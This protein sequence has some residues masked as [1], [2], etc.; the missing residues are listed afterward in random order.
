VLLAPALDSTARGQSIRAA[1]EAR[2]TPTEQ[3]SDK[4]LDV[5]ADTEHPQGIVAI[6][7]SPGWSLDH[8]E[9]GP[10]TV[11]LVLDGVQDPGN[12][13]TIL[14]TSFG[15]G[16]AGVIALP[17]TADLTNPQVLRG[18][19]GAF[20]KLPSVRVETDAYVSW[21]KQHALSVLTSAMDGRPVGTFG[22][23]KPCALVLGN[24]GAGIREELAGMGERVAIPLV[25]GAESLNV[26]VAAGILLY[27]V[28]RAG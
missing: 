13:G 25:A 10:R 21:A 5:L 16:A 1:L 22:N 23:Q 17:G 8:I 26:G 27:E 19:M 24:E 12:V 9:I 20:F 3:V 2:K 11:V 6:V 18:S 14:R 7:Q 28:M 4:E 15:L